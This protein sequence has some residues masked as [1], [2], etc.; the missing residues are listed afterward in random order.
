MKDYLNL[1]EASEQAQV[2]VATLRREIKQE[3]LKALKIGKAYIITQGDFKAYLMAR[4]KTTDPK[5]IK[6]LALSL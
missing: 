6:Q 5:K 4:Y 2:S 3:R 1:L